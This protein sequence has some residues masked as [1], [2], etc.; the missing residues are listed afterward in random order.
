M[1]IWTTLGHIIILLSSSLLLG[2]FFSRIGQSPLVGY[3]FAGMLLGGPGSVHLVGSEHE[4]EAISELGVAL[5]L[6]SL[7]LEFSVNRLKK[8]GVKPLLGGTLQVVFTIAVAYL[9]AVNFGLPAKES[10]AFGIMVSLS[11]TAIVLRILMEKA[12]LEAPHGRNSLAVLL[13]QDI[14]VVPLALIMT[15]LGN[16][17]PIQ[18][19][20]LDV[21]QLFLMAIGLVLLLYVLNK[22]ALLTLGMLT[23]HRNRE[24]TVIFA[25]V[26]GL[27]SSWAAHYAG[28]SPA[29]GAFVAGMMLGSSPFATQIRADIS[30]LRV[31]LLTLFFG[32]AGMLADPVWI[33][34]NWE[35]VLVVAMMV[36]IGKLLIVWLIFKLLGHS[37][38]VASSTGLALAQIGEF[39][40]VLGSIGR[41]N[42][43][44]SE[45]LYALVISV[46]IASFVLSAFLVPLAPAFGD[47]VANLSGATNKETSLS[48]ESKAP[49][50]IVIIGFGPS[51]QIASVPFIDTELNVVAIDLNREGIRKAKDLGFKGEIGDATQIEILEHLKLHEC[52][53]VIITVPHHQSALTILEN[54]RRLAPHACTFVRSRY[55]KDIDDFRKSGA[56]VVG[57]EREVGKGL[58]TSVD[59]W[60]KESKVLIG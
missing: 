6:F 11:S 34:Q 48:E 35:R 20:L 24:L 43:V 25:V 13:S 38:R 15:V 42:G 46:T 10:I 5:L 27:G 53:A 60:L 18:S 17:G 33:I 50:D 28:I 37:T 57:D 2:G 55:E 32:A 14:A 3:L 41:V 9:L 47:W 21:G 30:P 52:K 40:F 51:G 4:I 26:A 7:G 54:V 58:A 16:N 49:I 56:Q 29:L 31:I 23:L 36:T 8:L 44:V 12:V 59:E 45:E 39:A 22:V 1:D 19:V